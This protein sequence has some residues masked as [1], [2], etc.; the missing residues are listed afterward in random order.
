M[1]TALGIDVR[2]TFTLV[3]A[4]GGALA[5]LAGVLSG[6]YFGSVDPGSRDVAPH[7]RLHRRRHR[8]L[9][10]DRGLGGRGGR[11]RARPAVRE[12]LRRRLARLERGGRRLGDA[13][14]RDRPPAPAR[15]PRAEGGALM[16]T[17]GVVLR[18][19][20]RPPCS[21]SSS[22]CRSSR[23]ISR[24][25]FPARSTRPARSS[26][27]LSASSSPGL[28]SRTT[29]SS[30]SPGSCRSG[31]LSTSRSASTCRRS[32]SRSGTGAFR[33]RSLSSALVAHRRPA[34]ARRGQPAGG[35][36][37]LRD[38]HAR[39]RAGRERDRPDESARA[40]RRRRGDRR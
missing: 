36:D 32:R 3:F 31:T 40:D 10:L 34:R 20:F 6:I 17:R 15:G 7:L 33:R 19:R 30:A 18:S 27:S 1:V 28:R 16:S 26:C 24:A 13:A 5:A 37:R 14:P 9:R 4:L 21:R 39:V 12:L 8:R 11:G 35:W 29:S 38:G 2:K 23:S 25:C 22:S